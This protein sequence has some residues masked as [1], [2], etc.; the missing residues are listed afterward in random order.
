MCVNLSLH[1]FSPHYPYYRSSLIAQ[2]QQSHSPQKVRKQNQKKVPRLH[3]RQSRKTEAAPTESV[4]TQVVE[5]SEAAAESNPEE[6]AESAEIKTDG[7][8]EP[9]AENA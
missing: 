6:S 1:G 8:P 2:R 3:Q 4:E 9:A 5:T 7:E